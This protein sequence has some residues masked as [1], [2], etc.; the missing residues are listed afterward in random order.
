M[1]GFVKLLSPDK[2]GNVHSGE[3]GEGSGMYVGNYGDRNYGDSA[4]NSCVRGRLL[5]TVSFQGAFRHCHCNCSLS[6]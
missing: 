1:A 6:I 4:L 3:Y 2:D 5:P